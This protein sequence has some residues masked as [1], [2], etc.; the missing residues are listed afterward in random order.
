MAASLIEDEKKKR[1]FV[2]RRV[3]AADKAEV[4][5]PLSTDVY[6]GHDYLPLV[7]DKWLTDGY[8]TMLC[9]EGQ[10]SD[11]AGLDTV[12]TYDGGRTLMSQALRV[13]PAYRGQGVARVLADAIAQHIEEHHADAEALRVTTMGSNE[14]SVGLH[15]R[16]GYKQ[17]GFCLFYRVLITS[18]ASTLVSPP[19]LHRLTSHEFHAHVTKHCAPP[20]GTLFVD[21]WTPN[22]TLEN[23]QWVESLGAYFVQSG[24]LVAVCYWNPRVCGWHLSSTVLGANTTPLDPTVLSA[25]LYSVVLDALT[26][27]NERP[28]E[29]A[30]VDF[31]IEGVEQEAIALLKPLIPTTLAD[32]AVLLEKKLT[33]KIA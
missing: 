2:V 1:N 17:T 23:I 29:N 9:V 5:G 15:L 22:F 33:P 24:D 14:V 4:V 30:W 27:R 20:H 8:H 18:E 28:S 32:S 31:F 21:W 16:Q 12:T 3:V 19:K 11:I 7:F 10:G 25:F 6:W 26:Q 13:H